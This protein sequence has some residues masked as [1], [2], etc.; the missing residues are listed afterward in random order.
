MP[1]HCAYCEGLSLSMH[2]RNV[3]S[4]NWMRNKN[5]TINGNTRFCFFVMIIFKIYWD[6]AWVNQTKAIEL[7][8]QRLW[9][10]IIIYSHMNEKER[11]KIRKKWKRKI[12]VSWLMNHKHRQPA[13]IEMWATNVSIERQ[14]KLRDHNKT[15]F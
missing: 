14:I 9:W 10:K 4:N 15:E 12:D 6:E 3:H 2:F 5:S 1:V 13:L 7:N 8:S 11:K